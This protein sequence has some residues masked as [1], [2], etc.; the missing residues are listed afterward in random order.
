MKTANQRNAEN[1]KARL[2][3]NTAKYDI[4]NLLG[5]FECELAKEPKDI[6]WATTG[7]LWRVKQELLETLSCWSGICQ[8]RIVESLEDAR[9]VKQN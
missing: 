6:N 1:T 5:W 4:T 2:A 3:Y 8:D 7:T 9:K